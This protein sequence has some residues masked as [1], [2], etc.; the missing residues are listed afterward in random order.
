MARPYG[1]ATV[2]S[3]AISRGQEGA[4]HVVRLDLE[5]EVLEFGLARP[6]NL[7]LQAKHTVSDL[8][9]ISVANSQKE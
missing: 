9:R 4:L 3:W 8:L 1:N 2:E 5:E 6:A 7:R